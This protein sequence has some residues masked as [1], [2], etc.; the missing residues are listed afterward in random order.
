MY[1]QPRPVSRGRV[2]SHCRFTGVS[3]RKRLG[4]V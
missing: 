1:A 4:G 2:L 3:H